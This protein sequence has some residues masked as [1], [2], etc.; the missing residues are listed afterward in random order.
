[1]GEQDAHGV[2]QGSSDWRASPELDNGLLG[3]VHNLP[4]QA[5]SPADLA[6]KVSLTFLMETRQVWIENSSKEGLVYSYSF[7]FFGPYI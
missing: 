5:I 4:L 2:L 1:M 3:I 7:I 6:G